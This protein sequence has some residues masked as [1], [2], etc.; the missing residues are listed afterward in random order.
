MEQKVVLVETGQEFESLEKCSE[1]LQIPAKE[2]AD[3]I[4]TG[5]AVNNV[6]FKYVED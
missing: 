2:I 5:N 3:A 6:H 4:T 1:C